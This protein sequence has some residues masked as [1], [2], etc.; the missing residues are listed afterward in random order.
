MSSSNRN[1]HICIN[2]KIECKFREPDTSCLLIGSCCHQKIVNMV[3]IEKL[4][5]KHG[6]ERSVNLYSFVVSVIHMVNKR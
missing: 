6:V 3:E 2:S 5:D 1:Y 4:I